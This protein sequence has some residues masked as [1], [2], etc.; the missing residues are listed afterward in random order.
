MNNFQ[1]KYTS[2]CIEK[3]LIKSE[4]ERL[5]KKFVDCCDDIR[6]N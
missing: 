3:N 5:S 4:N 2:F 1:E 6:T